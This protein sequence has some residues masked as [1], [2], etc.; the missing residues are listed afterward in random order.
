MDRIYLVIDLKSFYASVECVERGLDPM[1]AKLVV[2]DPD[3]TEKTICLAVSPAMKALGVKNR[4]RVFEIPKSIDYIMAPPRM[5]KYIDYAAEIYGVYLKYIAPE[6]IYVYSIDEAFLDITNYLSMYQKTPKE[7]AVFLMEQVKEKVGVRAT[8]G[9][10]TNMYLAK[11]ALDITAKHAKDFI[12]ELTEESFKKTLWNHEPLSDFWRIGPGI[13]SHL[14][15]LGIRTMEQIANANEDLLYRE[16]GKDAELLIDHA[17]GKEPVTM[18]DIKAYKPKTNSITQGQV[19]MS[20]YSFEDGELIIREM[21]DQLCL[22]LVKRNMVTNSITL[23]IGYSRTS[24]PK[25]ES[26]SSAPWASFMGAMVGGT[27]SLDF[28]TSSDSVWIAKAVELYREIVDPR[29]KIRR[30]FVNANN[31]HEDTGEMQISMFSE[32]SEKLENDKKIQETMLKVKSRFGKNAILKGMDYKEKAMTKI[33]N[34]Q[35]GGHKSGQ[36]TD[37]PDGRI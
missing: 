12:G 28:D 20:D 8:C 37:G 2:A 32:S 11:I 5:Q 13:E 35:I 25:V 24:G 16:F 22:D 18:A 26:T 14:A 19:L 7:M 4:C 17:Y 36:E 3:R 33:R 27:A 1:T 15:R 31:I 29:Y 21:T 34:G 6:D 23:M 30:V 10:G 9:I